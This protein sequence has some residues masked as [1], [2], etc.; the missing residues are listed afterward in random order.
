MNVTL[1]G[2]PRQTDASTLAQA[3]IQFGFADALVATAV[4]GGFVPRSGRDSRVIGE[5]DMI[6]V[7]APMQGG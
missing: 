2:R 5:G 4:N 6:E 3:L 7:L 1:N